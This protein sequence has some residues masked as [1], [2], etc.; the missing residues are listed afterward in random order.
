[1]SIPIALFFY[2][3]VFVI[4][5][6]I[7]YSCFN[8]YHLLRF[9]HLTWGTIST[10]VVYILVAAI[11]L[12]ISFFYINQINWQQEITLYPAIIQ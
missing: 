4:L 7:L 3:Y 5:V 9:G 2:L 12:T 1:M 8:I 10:L 11:I 6:F